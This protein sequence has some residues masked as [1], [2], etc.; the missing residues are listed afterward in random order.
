MQSRKRAFAGLGAA[1]E[2]DHLST[3]KKHPQSGRRAHA[4]SGR[5]SRG[6][7]ALLDPKTRDARGLPEAVGA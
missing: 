7:G 6:H 5:L 4:V 2:L 3:G 1:Q